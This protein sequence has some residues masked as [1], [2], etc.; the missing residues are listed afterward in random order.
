V[1]PAADT[2]GF[3]DGKGSVARSVVR[4]IALNLEIDVSHHE[5]L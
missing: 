3:I 1:R 4:H 2:S 5:T